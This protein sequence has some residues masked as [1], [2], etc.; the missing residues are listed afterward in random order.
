MFCLVRLFP[1]TND[2]FETFSDIYLTVYGMMRSDIVLIQGQCESRCCCVYI[3]ACQAH[4]ILVFLLILNNSAW[5][6]WSACSG[7]EFTGDHTSLA[8]NNMYLYV[9]IFSCSKQ[10]NLPGEAF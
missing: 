10:K 7:G 3:V 8:R 4:P 9:S 5:F 6:V 2:F 1:V